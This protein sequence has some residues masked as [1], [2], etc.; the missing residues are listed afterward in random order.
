MPDTN[1]IIPSPDAVLKQK[2]EYIDKQRQSFL[3]TLVS[4]IVKKIQ[5]Y[6]SND[7][8][9]NNIIIDLELLVKKDKETYKKYWDI[10][11][12]TLEKIFYEAGYEYHC[13]IKKHAEYYWTGGRDSRYVEASGSQYY[14][15]YI[16]L[17]PKPKPKE[18]I[19][20]VKEEEII[21]HKE[22]V[23]YIVKEC[24]VC[25]ENP[26]DVAVKKCGHVCMCLECANKLDKCPI[27]RKH[28]KFDKHLLKVYL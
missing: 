7:Q 5:F 3:D 27:C 25:E 15:P 12:S 23:N 9:S 20:Q 28:Y 2:E 16:T 1:I 11:K 4:E 22:E 14:A 18:I 6:A 17:K 19:K 10:C 24:C 21:E 8:P 26:K 13:E